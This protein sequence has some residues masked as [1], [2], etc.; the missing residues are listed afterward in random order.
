MTFITCDISGIS[1]NCEVLDDD[2]LRLKSGNLDGAIG[3]DGSDEQP[4]YVGE[5]RAIREQMRDAELSV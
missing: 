4:A 3:P 1:G 2:G 5:V